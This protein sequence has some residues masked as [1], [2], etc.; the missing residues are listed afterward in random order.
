MSK[1]ALHSTRIELGAAARVPA[2]LA[3][4]AALDLALCVRC[5][6][7]SRQRATR[8]LFRFM[9]RIGDGM[10][11]YALMIALPVLYGARAWP[12]VGKMV[13]AGA[14]GLAL[15]KWLKRKTLRPR[16]Y[17]VHPVIEAAAAPLDHFSFPSG[18]TLHAVSMALIV[19]CHFTELAP[20][21]AAAAALIAASRPILGLHYPSDV[22]AGAAIGGTLATGLM[23]LPF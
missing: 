23:L 19:G 21:V 18:H 9:S 22:A 15:Y 14:L 5:N 10:L 3:R 17:Q 2:G 7:A 13:L 6:R 20:A 12:V 8:G 11:W 4:L 1:A 16:P